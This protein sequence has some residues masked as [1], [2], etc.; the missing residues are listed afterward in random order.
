MGREPFL[1]GGQCPLSSV[2][3][4]VL[5]SSALPQVCSLP[6]VPESL[7][8]LPHGWKKAPRALLPCRTLAAWSGQARCLGGDTWP[9]LTWDG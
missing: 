4:S 1:S 8:Q 7:A 6:P 3:V 9:A 2:T 5:S